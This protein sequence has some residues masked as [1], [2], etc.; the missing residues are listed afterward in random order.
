MGELGRTF[1]SGDSRRRDL[2]SGS[3]FKNRKNNEVT[4]H[5][6]RETRK[7]KREE[8][9]CWIRFLQITR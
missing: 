8:K 1:V 2:S 4:M 3:P 7:R 6:G 5:T 9:I